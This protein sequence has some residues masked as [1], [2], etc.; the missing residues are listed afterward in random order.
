MKRSHSRHSYPYDKAL[1]KET[2]EGATTPQ[3]EVM[4]DMHHTKQRQHDHEL[5]ELAKNECPL[6]KSK[7]FEPSRTGTGCT[8]CDGTE[9]GNP[10]EEQYEEIFG[11]K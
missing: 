8:F 1:P 6:C 10:P 9:G 2:A 4:K 3:R 5:T 11:G 7:G